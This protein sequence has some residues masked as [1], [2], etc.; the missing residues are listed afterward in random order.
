MYSCIVPRVLS[1]IA[2][3]ALYMASAATVSAGV[4]SE[5]YTVSYTPSTGQNTGP[6]SFG[7]NLP[8]GYNP[9]ATPTF[10]ALSNVVN[11]QLSFITINPSGSCGTGCGTPNPTQSGT[12]TVHMNFIDGGQT[13]SLT[14]TGTY[15]AQYNAM[16]SYLPCKGI[17]GTG[18]SDCID[19][20]TT[21]QASQSDTRLLTFTNGDVLH[22]TFYN[23]EDWSITPYISFLETRAVPLPGTLLLF[24]SGLG[25]LGLLG[26]RRKRKAQAAA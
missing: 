24:A 23:A 25:A 26:W 14:E 13:L 18:V 15:Q 1:A 16:A 19:W 10:Q 9:P 17:S 22:V 2:V 3:S 8:G 7:Y 11:G 6:S 12:V 4:I 21:T 5:D 20:G